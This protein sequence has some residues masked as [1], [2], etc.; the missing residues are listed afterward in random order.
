MCVCVCVCV[1]VFVCVCFLSLHYPVIQMLSEVRLTLSF[2]KCGIE[3]KRTLQNLV[4]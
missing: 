1:C 2:P 3:K 4:V